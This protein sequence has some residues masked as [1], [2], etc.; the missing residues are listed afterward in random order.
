[1]ARALP[2]ALVL[3][4]VAIMAAPAEA[5]TAAPPVNVA[6][7]SV[8]TSFPNA[9]GVFL[10]VPLN[11]TGVLVYPEWHADFA[12]SSNA[13]YTIYVGG[14]N[15]ASGAVLGQKHVTFNVTGAQASVLIGFAGVPYS[16]TDEPVAQVSVT[17]PPPP[18]P[19]EYTASQFENALLTGQLQAYGVVALAVLG[20]FFS[21]RK[22]VIVNR[23]ARASRLL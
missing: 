14:L 1:M 20:S 11:S 7:L 6:S 21:A 19:L 17:T 5:T 23:K 9:G 3:V 15:V 22:I 2:I 16:F 12:S 13:S 10:Y 4:A 8:W 18:P